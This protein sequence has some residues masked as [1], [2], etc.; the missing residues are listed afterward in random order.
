MTVR[1]DAGH[2]AGNRDTGTLLTEQNLRA[3]NDAV[4]HLAV[5]VLVK[6][7]LD[8]DVPAPNPPHGRVVRRVVVRVYVMELI[9]GVLLLVV[10]VA[11]VGG[12]VVRN[13]K[14][15]AP[16]VGD[17]HEI[18]KLKVAAVIQAEGLGLLADLAPFGC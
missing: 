12:D 15:H 5:T 7:E 3:D 9:P 13:I 8:P 1:H 6:V 16:E 18:V 2:D 14:A 11:P 10:R 17:R 4:L